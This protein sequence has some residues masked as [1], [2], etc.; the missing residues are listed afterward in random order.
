MRKSGTDAK[1]KGYGVGDD[2]EECRKFAREFIGYDGTIGPRY[3]EMIGSDFIKNIQERSKK[4][5]MEF[6]KYGL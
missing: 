1:T 3:E 4:I 6:V 5:Y 2:K